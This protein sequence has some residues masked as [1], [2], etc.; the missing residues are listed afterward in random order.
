MGEKA[1][2]LCDSARHEAINN[3]AHAEV[4]AGTYDE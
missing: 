4:E 3:M 2:V 1:N